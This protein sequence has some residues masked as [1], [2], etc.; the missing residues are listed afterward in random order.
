MFGVCWL[1]GKEKIAG[2]HEKK[3]DT[4]RVI[5]TETETEVQIQVQIQVQIR[6]K[7]QI[8]GLYGRAGVPG[9]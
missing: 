3:R 7:V 6:I 9:R 4:L 5:N 2:G 8:C 1:N